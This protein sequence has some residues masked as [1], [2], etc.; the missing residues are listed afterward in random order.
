MEE[1]RNLYSQLNTELKGKDLLQKQLG[2]LEKVKSNSEQAQK[3]IESLVS[4]LRKISLRLQDNKI[5]DTLQSEI[6]SVENQIK[7]LDYN[8]EKLSLIQAEVNNWKWAE[9]K[10]QQIKDAEDNLNKINEF[11]PKLE[12]KINFLVFVAFL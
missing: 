12:I 8:P 2:E 10:N 6:S 3:E 11:L 9:L 1:Y 7:E 4:E 5:N